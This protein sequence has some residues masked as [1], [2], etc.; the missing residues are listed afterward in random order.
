MCTTCALSLLHVCFMYVSSS[1]RGIKITINKRRGSRLLTNVDAVQRVANKHATSHIN[2]LA[3]DEE[4]THAAD[5]PPLYSSTSADQTDVSVPADI[6]F[7][8]RRNLTQPTLHQIHSKQSS[9]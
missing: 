8:P 3:V 5:K 4:T 1:K 6:Q 9:K 2:R 7:L